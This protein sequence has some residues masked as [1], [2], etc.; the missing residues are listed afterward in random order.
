M[1]DTQQ[2]WLVVWK[3][4][5]ADPSPFEIEEAAPEVAAILG[6]SER[7][8]IRATS[9]L[10]KELER[11]PEGRQFFRVEGNAIVCLD[12]FS[13]SAKDEKAALDAYPFEL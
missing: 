12:E 5:C 9:G 3:H 4:A 13:A 7:D 2:I 8:A 6:I 1:S 10:M 11:M